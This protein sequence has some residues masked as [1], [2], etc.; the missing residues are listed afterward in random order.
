MFNCIDVH[1]TVDGGAYVAGT[2][3]KF[4]DY[5]PYLYKTTDY[6][7]TWTRINRGIPDT[8]YTRAI[9]ADLHRP[10]LLYAGTEWGMYVSFDDGANWQ[11]FQLNL[12]IVAIRDLHVRDKMLIAATHGRSFW[13]IDDLSPLHQL[14]AE[15]AQAD[16]YLFAPK[17][18]YRMAQGGR[19]GRDARK[20]GENHPD[21]VQFHFFLK[22]YDATTD[23]VQ[24]EILENDGSLIR[25]YRSTAK[26][27]DDKLEVTEGGNRFTWDLR[28]PGFKEFPGMVLY[29][30][31]NRGPKA[32]PG[33]YLARLSVNGDTVEQT[34]E[35]IGDPRLPNTEEDY[36]DQ[37]DF[38]ITVRD[39]VS[40]AHQAMLDI[41]ALREDLDYLK[42]KLREEG[43]HAAILAMAEALNKEMTAIEQQIHMTKN[44]SRQDPLNY[45]IKVNNRLAFLLAD[46]QR[47]DFPPTDQAELVRQELTAELDGYLRELEQLFESEVPKIN[48]A[49]QDAEVGMLKKPKS[50]KP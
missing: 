34:F 27:G 41:R 9:R 7:Q 18:A 49:L 32:I 20:E 26:K 17:P 6:G 35:I 36:R 45:G 28:Y 23:E 14:S 43:D 11:P 21:G 40:E 37:F 8:Y 30:S 2:A 47:G 3:Y 13:M 12:P 19:G 16:F 39:K 48:E 46:Q 22:D 50:R 10:G 29:S 1:P 42:G 44:E 38:L 15:V 31:P 5:T 25:T 33:E 24:L 4:G